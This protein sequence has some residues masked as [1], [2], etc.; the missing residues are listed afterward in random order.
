M[1]PRITRF[2][3]ALSAAAV[4]V[5]LSGYGLAT[6]GWPLLI[7]VAPAIAA[8]L[9]AQSDLDSVLAALSGAAVGAGL[10]PLAA[11]PASIAL[12][13]S[14]LLN[15]VVLIAM[16]GLLTWGLRTL[17]SRA[18]KAA[19]LLPWFG[20]AAV[21]LML[22]ATALPVAGSPT[23]SGG[24]PLTAILR[25]DPGI[26]PSASDEML[27]AA[28][29][30]RIARG[31]NYYSAARDVLA[32]AGNRVNEDSALSYRMPTLFLV[33]AALPGVPLVGLML[34]LATLAVVSAFALSSQLVKPPLALVSAAAVAGFFAQPAS[35]VQ[36]MSTEPWAAAHAV[37]SVTCAV[38]AM[39]SE[40]RRAW[41][42]AAAALSLG[43][44]LF[45]E[46]L[47]FVPL[48]GLL[49]A[50]VLPQTRI[51]R[52]WVPWLV[53]LAVWTLLFALHI[54][55]TGVQLL[56]GASGGSWLHPGFAQ[57][58]ASLQWG[59]GLLG[60]MPWTP[61]ALAAAAVAGAALTKDRAVR[62][63]LLLVTALPVVGLFFL[64]PN[65]AALDGSLPGYWGGAVMPI[66][67]ACSAGAFAVVSMAR[68]ARTAA[69]PAER[70]ETTP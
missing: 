65:G 26:T 63:L 45:R 4:I 32:E 40:R 1:S 35:S 12:G 27:Y 15:A 55:A 11:Q 25:S 41:L 19:N 48:A 16:C 38:I 69:R 42:I 20:V 24:A 54:R 7:C 68:R 37:A 60:G 14:R 57:W 58:S 67:Y 61:Y 33:W 29:A 23:P 2:A 17:L 47:I 6:A 28:Y 39:N 43:A 59:Q 53:T 13:P 52:D 21:S 3:L 10:A 18:P 70:E 30:A 51:R 66:V 5:A 22:W 36:I 46:L 64:G 44:A 9:V 56:G 8:A 49:T 34:A 50:L 62:L 31:E